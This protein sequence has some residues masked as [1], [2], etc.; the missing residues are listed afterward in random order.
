MIQGGDPEG[1]GMGGES[2]WGEG[3]GIE[4]SEN[5]RNFRGALS[6]ARAQDPNSNGSQ[7]FI[8]NAKTV[9]DSDLDYAEQNSG[10]EIPDS[11]REKYKESRRI[12]LF[13]RQLYCFRPGDRR[14]GCCGSDFGL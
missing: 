10:A 7:F 2:I 1:T 13:R 3:F 9:T 6:M 12:S 5:L 8:V 14:N 11:V 4:I